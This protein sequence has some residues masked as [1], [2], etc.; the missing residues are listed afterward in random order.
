MPPADTSDREI[1]V[2]RVIDAPR[3]LVWE[4]WTKQ[5]H[6]EQ[7]WGPNGFSVTTLEIDIREGGQWRFIM[8]GPDGRNYPNHIV[9]TKLKKPELIAHDHGGDDG[10]VHFKATITFEE[11]R[12]KTFLTMRST[13]LT[14]EERERVVK[15]YG[16][17][18]GARQTIGRLAEYIKNM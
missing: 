12:G 15:E 3:E 10:K 6:L 5:E 18:E 2:S 16:A 1:V 9:F 8:H 4:A 11:K 17:L 14:P 13:F 7:W